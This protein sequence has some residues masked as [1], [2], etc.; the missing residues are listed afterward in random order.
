MTTSLP[1]IPPLDLMMALDE[2]AELVAHPCECGDHRCSC[3]DHR[4]EC[5][6]GCGDFVQVNGLGIAWC[7]TIDCAHQVALEHHAEINGIRI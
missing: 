6:G 3:H 7:G 2:I 1:S 4:A 5:A